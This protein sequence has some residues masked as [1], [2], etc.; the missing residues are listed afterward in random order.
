[1]CGMCGKCVE[2]IIED[3]VTMQLGLKFCQLGNGLIN[4]ELWRT[5][6]NAPQCPYLMSIFCNH[7]RLCMCICPTKFIEKSTLVPLLGP[8][9][10][11]I[12]MYIHVWCTDHTFYV[13]PRQLLTTNISNNMLAYDTS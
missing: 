10:I 9:H 7:G 2:C 13:T 5:K 3:M 1:M 8:L 12:Y 4:G 11:F 6:H